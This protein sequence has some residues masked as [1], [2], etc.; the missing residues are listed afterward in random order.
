MELY[1]YSTV[2]KSSYQRLKSNFSTIGKQQVESKCASTTTSTYN[3]IKHCIIL[4]VYQQENYGSTAIKYQ[5]TTV[6]LNSIALAPMN[7]ICLHH[8]YHHV[9]LAR[10]PDPPQSRDEANPELHNEVVYEMLGFSCR[11][12]KDDE[13]F[14]VWNRDNW[15]CNNC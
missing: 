9:L 10:Y 1:I 5:S 7:P 3:S 14:F 13:Y 15:R 4:S 12:L 6:T 8:Q 2:L 11:L